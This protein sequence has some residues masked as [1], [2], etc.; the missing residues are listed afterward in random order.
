MEN[1]EEYKKIETFFKT[2]E[3]QE[4]LDEI[5][6]HSRSTKLPLK[7]E[8][9]TVEEYDK[10]RLNKQLSEAMIHAYIH[11]TSIILHLSENELSGYVLDYF[12]EKEVM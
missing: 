8:K 10:L 7:D 1:K 2:K 6:W 5:K 12:R 3:G 11:A 4:I 9:H